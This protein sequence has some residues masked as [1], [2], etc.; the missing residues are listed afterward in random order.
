MQLEARRQPAARILIIDDDEVLLAAL[1]WPIKRR[2]TNVIVDTAD[3]P[4]SA[5]AHLYSTEYDAV[6]S[7]I[8]MP[9]MDGVTLLRKVTA[10][11]P[12]TPVILFTGYGDAALRREANLNGA[13]AF[14]IKPLDPQ[15][16]VELLKRAIVERRLSLQLIQKKV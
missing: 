2:M 14:I 10:L 5:L 16:L 7:D 6:L 12:S 13:Y 1:P 11:Q 8:S 15:F 9:R 4:E 3:T